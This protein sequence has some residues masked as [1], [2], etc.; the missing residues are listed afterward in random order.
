M[1][2]H[3]NW[4]RLRPSP[5]IESLGRLGSAEEIT[6]ALGKYASAFGKITA[7]MP[8]P[9]MEGQGADHWGFLVCFDKTLDA[10]AA[11]RSWH[12][13]LFGVTSVIVAIRCYADLQVSSERDVGATIN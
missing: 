4:D 6:G 13:L 7:V 12:C 2:T 8:L 10:M 11:S 9:Q 5:E 1:N 3:V